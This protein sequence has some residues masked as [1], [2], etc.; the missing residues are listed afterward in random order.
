MPVSDPSQPW[1]DPRVANVSFGLSFEEDNYQEDLEM[2][3][4]GEY[5]EEE[6]IAEILHRLSSSPQALSRLEDEAV[7]EISGLARRRIYT[8]GHDSY[9]ALVCVFG[10]DSWAEFLD[11][12]ARVFARLTE[13]GGNDSL[14]NTP[15]M[16]FEG[17]RL[18]TAEG[19]AFVPAKDAGYF[20]LPSIE[21]LLLAAEPLPT[22][23][24]PKKVLTRQAL[25]TRLRD[26]S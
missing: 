24:G 17:F 11:L 21:D 25:S 6:P 5:S 23:R 16:R 20:E 12:W 3:R 2:L 9:D 7:R 26:L 22:L 18:E 13:D 8:Q 15:Y 19:L 10:I 4:K 1:F 14:D